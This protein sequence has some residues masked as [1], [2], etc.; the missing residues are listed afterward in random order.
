[1]KNN[2]LYFFLLLV[3][4][5]H[6]LYPIWIAQNNIGSSQMDSIKFLMLLFCSLG[7]VFLGGSVI[8]GGVKSLFLLK[9]THSS[10]FNSSSAIIITSVMTA[11]TTYLAF[12]HQNQTQKITNQTSQ[13]DNSNQNDSLNQNLPT[14][15]KNMDSI[16]NLPKSQILIDSNINPN[17]NL[18]LN[19]HNNKTLTENSSKDTINYSVANDSNKSTIDSS[20]N[21][22]SEDIT[23]ESSY[24]H[25]EPVHS[26]IKFNNPL[27]NIHSERI[28]D[29]WVRTPRKSDISYGSNKYF[30]LYPNE[31]QFSKNALNNFLQSDLFIVNIS[32]QRNDYYTILKVVRKHEDFYTVE[33]HIFHENENR[34]ISNYF[35]L[36]SPHKFY[37]IKEAINTNEFMLSRL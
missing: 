17:S 19:N 9:A 8:S 32:T 14:N 20:I 30:I 37:N 2:K 5:L 16:V 34:N 10:M 18:I 26:K 36:F 7:G 1:M 23:N 33:Y 6:L 22:N 12:L 28:N 4:F 31:M 24:F 3:C 21:E 35:R 15:H 29:I 27:A 25:L 11:S 13:L